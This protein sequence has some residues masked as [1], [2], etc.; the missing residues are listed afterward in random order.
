MSAGPQ[1]GYTESCLYNDHY[2]AC[3]AG[4]CR[5]DCH[6]N[7]P[8]H[9]LWKQAQEAKAA[10]AEAS[11]VPNIA[12]PKIVDIKGAAA[13][14]GVLAKA[15]QPLY[16]PL[17]KEGR[18]ANE[19]FCREDGSP[20]SSTIC[21]NCKAIAEPSDLYCYKCGVKLSEANRAVAELAPAEAPEPEAGPILEGH[22][23]AAAV[24]S[25]AEIE[26][27]QQLLSAMN[28]ADPTVA[29]DMAADIMF[30]L[31]QKRLRKE[32][33]LESPGEVKVSFGLGGVLEHGAARPAS[34]MRGPAEAGRMGPQQA[35]E[36]QPPAKPQRPKGFRLPAGAIK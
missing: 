3:R 28:A 29:G 16:C 34:R 35:T 5:C 17:C 23:E 20:L 21:G 1:V 22:A 19:R 12:V 36:T 11:A 9:F 25:P 33:L 7:Q 24:E 13:T 30:G 2:P 10:V 26:R 14:S 8:G 32:G 6:K 31:E 4:N 27:A 18:P 15:P